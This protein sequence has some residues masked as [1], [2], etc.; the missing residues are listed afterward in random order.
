MQLSVD[1]SN[2]AKVYRRYFSADLPKEVPSKS[3]VQFTLKYRLGASDVW[4]W[5]NE[6]SSLTDGELY[7]QPQRPPSDLIDYLKDISP[8][9]TV[10]L[11]QSDTPDTQ[12][13]SIASP[14]KAAQEQHSGWTNLSLGTPRDFTRWFSLVRIWSPWLAPRH[15]QGHFAPS[16]DAILCSF[17]RW[18][19]LHFVILAVSGVDDVLTVFKP[20][21]QGNVII[22]A[23]NDRPEPNTAKIIAAVGTTFEQAN[24]AVMYHARKLVRGDEYMSD[25]VKAEMKSAIENDVRAE[26]MENWYDGLTYCTWNALGQD[27]KEEKIYNALDILKENNIKSTSS[28]PKFKYMCLPA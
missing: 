19:G 18:D 6:D 12:L 2:R 21:G 25:E 4:K 7:F 1:S 9:I 3:S 24:A 11:V 5:V 13:W 10:H 8:E 27:L 22:S 20:D 17:L 28:S 14:V 26:W 23:R 15:G 16:E